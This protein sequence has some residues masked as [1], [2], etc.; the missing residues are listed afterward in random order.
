[1]ALNNK[2]QAFISEY[3]TDYNATQAA[4][5]A[6]YSKRSASSI[7]EELLR[8]PEINNVIQVKREALAKANE[9]TAER[10]TAE[11]AKVAFTEGSRDKVKALDILARML[12]L[13]KSKTELST[14]PGQP[15]QIQ[16]GIPDELAEKINKKLTGG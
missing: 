6:G 10:I 5:R 4:I 9:V 14:P 16:S 7:G 15:I 1:M 13:I 2:Q 12:G 11:L 8:K 3:L